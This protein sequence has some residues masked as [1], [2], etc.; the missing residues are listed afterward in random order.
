MTTCCAPYWY[1]LCGQSPP[2]ALRL[3]RNVAVDER[4]GFAHAKLTNIVGSG[5]AICR[6]CGCPNP[7]TMF[8]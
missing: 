1:T 6:V 2:V 7:K 8:D 3:P 5:C 4:N